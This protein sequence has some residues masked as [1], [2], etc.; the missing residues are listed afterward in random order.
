MNEVDESVAQEYAQE[1]ASLSLHTIKVS[2]MSSG[3]RKRFVKFRFH[4]PARRRSK[5]EDAKIDSGAEANAMSISKYKEIY[6]DRVD[7]NGVPDQRFVRKSDKRLEAYGGVEIPHFG[8][9]NVPVEYAGKK[10]MCRFFLCDIEGSILLGL[11]TC[12]ALGI[13]RITIDNVSEGCVESQEMNQS[14]GKEGYISPS[15]PMS[16]RQAI[17]TKEDLLRMYPECF[18]PHGKFFKNFE[19]EIKIDPDVKPKIH[20]PRRCAIELKEKF[21]EK[22][23]EMKQRGIILKVDEPTPWVN[24]CVVETKPNGDI[25]VCLDPTD[26]NRAVLRDH[27]PIPVVEDIVPGLAGSDLFSKLDLKDGYWHVKLTERSSYLTTFSTPFG[28]FRYARLPFGL[29]VSQDV[30][31]RKID[32]TYGPCEGTIG[33]SDDV[34]LH[35]KG[36]KNHDQRLH[37]TVWRQ[38]GKPTSVSISKSW[39]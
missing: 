14:S 34:T 23:L 33:I 31:Q 21:R 3:T 19:Y 2:S 12:E 32:E 16:E 37:Q 15:V 30:F 36:E 8:T 5:V 25:R 27:H 26:L 7:E 22:L 38:H 13:I 17:N 1:F 24:S 10:F 28:K 6:P 29:C 4:D 35:G 18:D 9:V 39:K 20:P 11:P